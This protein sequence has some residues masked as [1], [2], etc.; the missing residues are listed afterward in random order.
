MAEGEQGRFELLNSLIEALGEH[1]A[2]KLMNELGT[3]TLAG[4]T[5]EN[6][7]SPRLRPRAQAGA[8]TCHPAA[9][10]SSAASVGL[11]RTAAL[12]CRFSQRSRCLAIACSHFS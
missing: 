10:S 4:R 3:V 11:L 2:H 6:S 12:S 5:G 7:W 8:V 9:F 1:V